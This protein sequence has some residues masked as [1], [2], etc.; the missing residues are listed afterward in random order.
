MDMDLGGLWEFVMDRE[1]LCSAIHGV[2]KSQTRLST[3]T[4]TE[5]IVLSRQE[6]WSRLPF[7]SPGDHVLSELFT[8]TLLSCV[9]LHC[10]AHFNK[11][12]SEADDL[13]DN[14]ILPSLNF[15]LVTLV[16][17]WHHDKVCQHDYRQLPFVWSFPKFRNWEKEYLSLVQ[18][19]SAQLCLS[20]ATVKLEEISLS[21]RP[22]I[23]HATI[24]T[25]DS[26][27]VSSL[28]Q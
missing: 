18:F 16:L 15:T 14:K 21:F 13:I 5:L 8:M 9:A 2:T 20:K 28:Y 1:A 23:F 4:E 7:S 24:D 17:Q 12:L 11:N 27:S 3:W 22:C 25:L 19:S 26:L 10:I 6:Y